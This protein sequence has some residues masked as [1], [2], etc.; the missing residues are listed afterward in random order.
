MAYLS[1]M[2][3]I[4]GFHLIYSHLISF[5][6]HQKDLDH[7]TLNI[8][9][10]FLSRVESLRMDASFL[11]TVPVIQDIQQAIDLGGSDQT[12]GSINQLKDRLAF[13][14]REMLIAK[15]HYLQL[16]LIGVANAGKE[17]VRVEWKGSRLQR[18]AEGLL[19]SKSGE[20]YYKES[21]KIPQ[22]NVY[23]SEFTLNREWSK[24]EFPPKMVIRAAAPIFD[25]EGKVFAVLV[26]NMLA[27]KALAGLIEFNNQEQFSNI[28]N[29]ELKYL[30]SSS[31]V[32][33][34]DKAKRELIEEDA[35][36][37]QKATLERP[38]TEGKAGGH[39]IVA[40]KLFYDPL[41]PD[42]FLGVVTRSPLSHLYSHIFEEFIYEIVLSI[43][44]ACI[45]IFFSFR[46]LKGQTRP[47]QNLRDLAKRL[48]RG[49]KVP[50]PEE[51]A[52][53][54][55]ELSELASAFYDM[56]DEIYLKSAMISAQ[57]DAV[58]ETALISE[59]DPG[60]LITYANDKFSHIS[61][62]CLEELIGSN[63]RIISSGYHSKSFFEN[64]WGTI[65]SG[66]IWRGE[67]KNKR[68][69][70]TYY[71]V[72]SSIVPIKDKNGKI[73]KYISVRFDITAKR[74]HEELVKEM[75]YELS[76]QKKLLE[77]S[78]R[79]ASLGEI[80]AGIAHEINNPLAIMLLK[81]D[82]L[83]EQYS[84]QSAIDSDAMK[85]FE[86]I[87]D[88]INRIS[89]ITSGLK[90]LSKG[91]NSNQNEACNIYFE[92][93]RSFDLVRELYRNKGIKISN[94]SKKSKT[95]VQ[96]PSTYIHQ[97]LLNLISNAKDALANNPDAEI[98]INVV[99]A[100]DS[101][102]LIVEDN[103]PGIPPDIQERIFEP[104]FTT[105]GVDEGTGIGLS[106]CFSMVNAVDGKLICD[107]NNQGTKFECKF[108]LAQK[109]K[110]A[111][112]LQAVNSNEGRNI[113]STNTIKILLVEDEAGFLEILADELS[114]IGHMVT[115]A[116]SAILALEI[117]KKEYFDVIISDRNM[118]QMDGTQFFAEIKAHNLA[119][120]T[121]KILM[122]ARINVDKEKYGID[123]T[124]MKPFRIKSLIPL[125]ANVENR[126]GK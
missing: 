8:T 120:N 14:F 61:G 31:E 38:M 76:H 30:A 22:G 11:A 113:S 90:Y 26:I 33:G 25:N 15:P 16:R 48:S 84:Q 95:L 80:S 18:T 114:K 123:A 23:L 85:S 3:V 10:D 116:N 53:K 97:I 115:S 64:L 96:C 54:D 73:E 58:D 98:K 94:N 13:I 89:N 86:F 70:G 34:G 101:V 104:F 78:S 88:A 12:D 74:A 27:Q 124:I 79:L 1:C 71:W 52:H 125:L 67:I 111:C 107:S 47:L 39:L 108:N 49:E 37:L 60:G 21:I 87:D 119:E 4:I 112:D 19:Q 121:F 59:T 100:G 50:R 126:I 6:S 5:E 105:K 62:F 68:K 42:R 99:E 46:S 32:L 43:F 24:V 82:D 92:V 77:T 118:P 56:A 20:T 63:H 65:S 51:L 93:K 66:R 102:S 122:S 103:G 7:Q 117:V 2:L 69:D 83:K 9:G 110:R 44:L 40:K 45:A 36:F 55:D 72:D 91:R 29:S 109:A 81:L 57:K 35:L 17:I 41:N 106:M 75:E 28:Y